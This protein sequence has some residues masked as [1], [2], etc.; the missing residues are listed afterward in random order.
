MG[1]VHLCAVVGSGHVGLLLVKLFSTLNVLE[2]CDWLIFPHILYIIVDL[3]SIA[4]MAA[5][6]VIIHL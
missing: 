3:T 5:D 6:P 4:M 2:L 1:F